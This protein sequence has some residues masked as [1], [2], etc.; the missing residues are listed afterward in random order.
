MNHRYWSRL[1][2]L[3][4]FSLLAMAGVAQE[5]RTTARVAFGY[6]QQPDGSYVDLTGT[7]I[8]LTIR[9][10]DAYNVK[11]G[12]RPL[13]NKPVDVTPQAETTVYENDRPDYYFYD[14]DMCSALDDLR[15]TGA[16]SGKPWSQMRV[17]VYARRSSGLVLLHMSCWETYT[18][19]RGAG[20]SAFDR[21][22]VNDYGLIVNTSQFFGEGGYTLDFDW[23]SSPNK[24]TVPGTNAF[25]SQTWREFNITGQGA[26]L[27]GVMS[28]LF[29]GGGNPTTGSS[30]DQFW[31]DLEPNMIF[32]ETE[33]DFF[34]GTP[35]ES[36]FLFKATVAQ[37]GTQ[38][39][40]K[41]IGVQVVRGKAVGGNVGSLHNV[42]LNYYRVQK[43]L[44]Q[45]QVEAPIQI[46]IDGFSGATNLTG[47]QFDLSSGVDTAGL[48][49]V[50]EAFNFRTGQ[51][52]AVD[53]RGATTADSR[54]LLNVPGVAADYVESGT[55]TVRARVSY[56]QVAP[57]QKQIWACRLDL[58]NWITSRP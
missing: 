1:V 26:F 37:S 49:Q 16:G 47:I 33:T 3:L 40:L 21:R 31:Y 23:S 39:T 5:V 22:F 34:G 43:F 30:D 56:R 32:D 24:I 53:S 58:F 41:P 35:N 27:V 52:I 54:M 38:E 14:P 57:V 10:V 8:P 11:W 44:V 50:T 20:N 7:E 4:T 29:S 17:G 42:D 45:N 25:T 55:G 18:T 15:P 46:I 2:A 12:W 6:A 9:K 19:G 51:W 13:D 28:P 36:N 48:G